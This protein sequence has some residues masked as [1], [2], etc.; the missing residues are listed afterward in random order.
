[1]TRMYVAN[2]SLQRH[3]FT[4]RIPEQIKERTVAIESMSQAVLPDDLTS[5]DVSVI[6]EQHH[7]YG[8][9]SIE[10][11]NSARTR[12]RTT[13]MYSLGKPISSLAIDTLF[14]LNKGILDEFGRQIRKE[15][16]VVSNMAIGRALEEQ[17]EQ[18]LQANIK[19]FEISVVEEEPAGGYTTPK[20]IAEGYR[21]GQEANAN[22]SPPPPTEPPPHRSLRSR[23]KG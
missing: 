6:I 15:T 19:Q 22:P 1:M 17:R 11:I 20:P 3:L 2:A 12:S 5:E 10:D 4:Y 8:F 9:I 13:L 7:Q 21:V 14:N 23:K 16:A 18:G